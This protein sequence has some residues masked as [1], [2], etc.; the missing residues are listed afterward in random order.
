MVKE[1]IKPVNKERKLGNYL[2]H[3]LVKPPLVYHR[4][5]S[6][7][8]PTSK[9]GP[10][11]KA[12]VIN[13]AA[14]ELSS[15]TQA[16]TQP[17]LGTQRKAASEEVPDSNRRPRLNTKTL[18][19]SVPKSYKERPYRIKFSALFKRAFLISYGVE[20]FDHTTSKTVFAEN[21]SGPRKLQ[22]SYQSESF[23]AGLL[24]ATFFGLPTRT[25]Q[26][27][28]ADQPSR[29]TF[30]FV[31][32]LKNMVGGW[33]NLY[34]EVSGSIDN[35]IDLTSLGTKNI[36]E[37][38]LTRTVEEDGEESEE[39]HKKTWKLV[40]SEKKIWQVVLFFPFK[41]PII[42]AFK[43]LGIVLKTAL[44]IVKLF[45]EFLPQIITNIIA[46]GFF[47]ATEKLRF[48]A[49]KNIHPLNKAAQLFGFG[50]VTLALGVINYTCRI[51]TLILRAATSPEKSARMAYAAGREYNFDSRSPE[52]F[53]TFSKAFGILAAAISISISVITWT[54]ALPLVIGAL[55][56]YL[57]VYLPSVFQTLSTVTQLPIVAK[58]LAV[59]NT[60]LSPVANTLL[61][62]A[63]PALS[64]ISTFLG[65]Q[66]PSLALILGTA[67]GGLAAP[68]TAIVS[69]IADELS[70]AWAVWH[71]KGQG[72]LNVI[73]A[74]FT[75]MINAIKIWHNPPH[76]TVHVLGETDNNQSQTSPQKKNSRSD[77]PLILVSEAVDAAHNAQSVV[78][79]TDRQAAAVQ[80]DTISPSPSTASDQNDFPL[81]LMSADVHLLVKDTFSNPRAREACELARE[82]KLWKDVMIRPNCYENQ[83]TA[84]V[85]ERV[86]QIE[87][88]V[89]EKDR[90]SNP[91]LQAIITAIKQC[92]ALRK[93]ESHSPVMANNP[94]KH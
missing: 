80:G 51:L 76:S 26:T 7:S 8:A 24:I 9:R 48:I 35:R 56:T 34:E 54:L 77:G 19:K 81:Y 62:V 30:T 50:L 87:A 3:Y 16:V 83:F 71:S 82:Y 72:P 40:W 63:G 75:R 70:N 74:L 93:K 57:P 55:M 4:D 66:I 46:T 89:L 11:E 5:A 88:E 37:A 52:E 1:F 6:P 28:A 41:F 36:S 18:A 44:N 20:G 65:V 85:Q 31:Q 33:E 49:S 73:G 53:E 84:E 59:L 47:N 29:L 23:G 17:D 68:I 79:S 32:F 12:E 92:V 38:P 91:R 45:T 2:H 90:N 42:F 43:L 10:A 13:A 94:R 25:Q 69:R 15:A 86:A 21:V 58:S 78:E 60:A 67:I 39:V 27:A 14:S 61:N 22:H 64:T